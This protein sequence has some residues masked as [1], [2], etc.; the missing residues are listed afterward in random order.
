MTEQHLTTP[1]NK[2]IILADLWIQYRDS[3][4]FRDF[5]EYND[6]ALPLAFMLTSGLA[7]ETSESMKFIDETFDLLLTSLNI[8]DQGYESIE[9]IFGFSQ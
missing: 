3:D 1:E 7:K 4:E 8:E 5:I 6:I 9:D 2:M